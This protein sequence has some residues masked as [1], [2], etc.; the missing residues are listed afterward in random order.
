MTN[1]SEHE[2]WV[3]EVWHTYLTTGKI[4]HSDMPGLSPKSLQRLMSR[5]PAEPRC[6][7]CQT[8]FHGVGGTL[9]R[10]V[11]DRGPSRLNPQ[12]CNACEQFAQAYQG[13]AEVEMSMLFADVRGS[14]RLAEGMSPSDFSQLINRFYKVATRILFRAHAMVEKIIGDEVTGLFVPG[15]A[16][17]AHARAAIEAA[18]AILEATGH[19]DPG[20]P[21]VPVG[22]GVHT[23]VAFMG[24]VGSEESVVDIVALGDAVNMAAHL[25]SQAG[26]GEVLV[27][28]TTGEAAGLD[29]GQL[30][31]RRLQLKSRT[32]QVNAY[33]VGIESDLSTE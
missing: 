8:P 12:I 27:S 30:E 7:L 2:A 25:A 18:Q 24:A 11:L 6:R 20:G 31:T 4:K 26:R 33:V 1:Q 15:F 14:T 32:E 28:A 21:W 3:E 13:G 29:T 5:L 9:V 23:G 19:N 22:I 17:A 16:G 10:L